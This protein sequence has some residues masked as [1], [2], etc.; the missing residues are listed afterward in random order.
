[1]ARK[2]CTDLKKGL[3]KGECKLMLKHGNVTL[4]QREGE[5]EPDVEQVEAGRGRLDSLPSWV[6]RSQ[7]SAWSSH[8]KHVAKSLLAPCCVFTHLQA[9]TDVWTACGGDMSGDSKQQAGWKAGRGEGQ[10]LFCPV[11][12]SNC[13]LKSLHCLTQAR[14]HNFPGRT[15]PMAK[16][17]LEKG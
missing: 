4:K 7:V 14:D 12:S 17:C 10:R 6:S 3:C 5:D 1:M 11:N 16:T 13:R 9:L 15:Q 2:G 8:W